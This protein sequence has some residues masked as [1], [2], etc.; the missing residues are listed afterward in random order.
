MLSSQKKQQQSVPKQYGSKT[1]ETVTQQV[2]TEEHI[3]TQSM[4]KH[5][6]IPTQK[7]KISSEK[8]GND[9]KYTLSWVT[10]LLIT[11]ALVK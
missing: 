8:T 6:Y 4:P 5:Q 11:L 9:K 7:P 2:F 1:Q 3:P 10:Q